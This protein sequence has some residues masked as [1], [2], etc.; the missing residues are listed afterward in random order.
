MG[1]LAASKV[2]ALVGASVT[3]ETP[4][5]SAVPVVETPVEQAAA[6]ALTVDLSDDEPA[7]TSPIFRRVV[8]IV[9]ALSAVAVVAMFGFGL[10]DARQGSEEAQPVV[11]PTTVPPTTSAPPTTTEA[12][13]TTTLPET[14][15]PTTTIPDPASVGAWGEPVDVSRLTLKADAIGPIEVGTP[16]ADAIGLLVASLG[17]PEAIEVAGEEYGLCA[18]EDGRVVR[19]AEL[20]AIVLGTLDD[21][22]FV[23]YQYREP[24]VPTRAIDLATPSGI[25]LGDDI[26]TLNEVYGRYTLNYETTSGKSTFQLSRDGELLLWGPISSSE[27]NGRVEGIYS[28]ASCTTSE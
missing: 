15:I 28:P 6:A 18:D 17:P 3:A 2:E 27:D 13:A 1:S 12:P 21:G 4:N 25:R 11:T 14:T 8:P 10:L 5:V 7:V 26:A 9:V 22:V 19:W 16:A 20:N 23:G 24:T